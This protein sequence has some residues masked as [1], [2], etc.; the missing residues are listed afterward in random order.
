MTREDQIREVVGPGAINRTA[1]GLEVVTYGS[2]EPGDHG[3]ASSDKG[4]VAPVQSGPSLLQQVV[5][6]AEEGDLGLAPSTEQE[7]RDHLSEVPVAT[8]LLWAARRLI[9]LGQLSRSR[10]DQLTLAEEIFGDAKIVEAYSDFLDHPD[11]GERRVLFHDQQFHVLLRLCFESCSASD[12]RAWSAEREGAMRRALLGASTLTGFGAAKL[13]AEALELKDWLGFFIQNGAYNASEQPLLAF[14]RTARIFIELAGSPEAKAHPAF[15]DFA[16]LAERHLG[17][18]LKE[19]FTVGLAV[20]AGAPAIRNDDPASFAVTPR[21]SD[22]LSST[23]LADRFDDLTEA[24]SQERA[25]YVNGFASSCDDPVR[26]AWDLTPMLQRP[27][28]RMPDGVLLLLSPPA[29]QS[30]LTDG[31]YY[32]LRD[33]AAIEDQRDAFTAFVGWLYEQYLLEVFQVGVGPQGRVHGEIRYGGQLSSDV[34]IEL[35][36]DL[37]LIEVV[38]TR[39][40]LGVRAEADQAELEKFLA[41][42]VIDKVNQLDRVIEDFQSERLRVPG[43]SPASVARI[44]PVL[45]NVGELTEGELLSSFIKERAPSALQ[46]PFV[47]PLTL[48]GVDDAETLAGMIAAGEGLVDVLAEKQADGYTELSLQ[49][50]LSDKRNGDAP[51]LAELEA[52]WLRISDESIELLELGSR[53]V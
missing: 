21:L 39:L 49:R 50:W 23:A 25:H 3:W 46:R 40:P 7:T 6:V 32:R 17:G 44:W 5:V 18:G 14:Q 11:A 43:A 33:A 16:G 9:R 13:Q 27:L 19:L 45:V 48:L 10:A 47:Q 24:L 20:M 28:Y 2:P 29:L 41:R 35:R 53:P 37:V 31:V 34:V 1:L 15:V 38:S 52:R 36:E 51:R 42:A 12:D 30:W 8:A 26:L 22:Y 4:V